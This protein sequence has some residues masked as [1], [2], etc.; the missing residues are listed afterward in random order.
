M[1]ITISVWNWIQ[2]SLD[3]LYIILG[4]ELTLFILFGLS[5]GVSKLIIEFLLF[6]KD[7]YL[8]RKTKKQILSVVLRAYQYLNENLKYLPRAKD[9]AKKFLDEIS[10]KFNR[11]MY[12]PCIVDNKPVFNKLNSAKN[13]V[14]HILGMASI[15][16]FDEEVL[17]KL[18][19]YGGLLSGKAMSNHEYQIEAARSFG[20]FER[21][22]AEIRK[23]CG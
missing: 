5:L 4:K 8:L 1:G 7:F 9:D 2:N 15:V 19:L 22:M 20:E 16:T 12:K 23:Y 3:V 10:A 11:I 14:L 6:V 18:Q 13:E 17:R 21:E